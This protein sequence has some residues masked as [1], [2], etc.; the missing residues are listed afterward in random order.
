LASLFLGRL[1]WDTGKLDYCSAGHPPAVLLR[2]DGHLESLSDGGTLLGVVSEASFVKGSVELRDGDV[3]VTYSDGILEARNYA[4]EEF[5][6][7]QLE[8]QVRRA[9]SGSADAVLFSVLGAVQDFVGG[10]PQAD[11]MSLVVVR[12]RTATRR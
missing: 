9:R 8:T 4:D 12:R 1:N 2:A 5:G 7:D 6:F 3:L 11:D 10:C